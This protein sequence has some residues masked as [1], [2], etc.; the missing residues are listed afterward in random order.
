[1]GGST[2]GRRGVGAGK[3]D[4]WDGVKWKI[5]A[6]KLLRVAEKNKWMCGR[7]AASDW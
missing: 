6:G 5:K 1:V 4:G 3:A 2:S 7:V